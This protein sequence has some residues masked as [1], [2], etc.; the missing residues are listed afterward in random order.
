M[1]GNV[2]LMGWLMGTEKA[3]LPPRAEEV[4]EA[5]LHVSQVRGA[6]SGGGALMVRARRRPAGDREVRQR[7][8]RS[9]ARGSA[10]CSNAKRA[11]RPCGAFLVQ[12]HVR[13]ATSGPATRE[14]SHPFRF[15]EAKQRG[16][17]PRVSEW[18]P[19]ASAGDP[20]DRDGD[21][22]QRRHGRAELPRGAPPYPDLGGFLE[23]VLVTRNRWT[24]T[25][26]CSRARSSCFSPRACGSSRSGSR[27]STWRAPPPDV[28]HACGRA[29]GSDARDRCA[30]LLDT[31]HAM[32][33][34]GGVRALAL[35]ERVWLATARE[36]AQRSTRRA[37]IDLSRRLAA[38]ARTARR[39]S[40]ALAR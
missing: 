17:A 37:R 21:H 11:A 26:R 30:R 36:R 40:A 16:T 34:L 23:H 5:M 38:V 8:A 29:S 39:R 2:T 31:A 24:A 3:A 1:C 25:R 13:F 10:R 7:Q 33:T 14:E 18:T 9:L 12:T 15:V 35:G 32:P 20:A 4:L 6:Q 22:A 19:R 28:H 27:T